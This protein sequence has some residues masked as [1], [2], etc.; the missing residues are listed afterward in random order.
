MNLTIQKLTLLTIIIWINPIYAGQPMASINGAACSF[1]TIADAISA[2]QPND[3]INIKAGTYNQLIGEIDMNL[4]LV[5]SDGVTGCEVGGNIFTTIDGSGQT[6]DATGGLVKVTNGAVVTFRDMALVNASAINGGIMAVLDE[7]S[8]F[9]DHVVIIN[10]SALTAGG[11]IYVDSTTGIESSLVLDN[12]SI[13][14]SGSVINGDGGGLAI[15]NSKLL[16]NNSTIGLMGMNEGNISSNNGAGIYAENSNLTINNFATQIQNNSANNDGGGIY[17][18]DSSLTITEAIVKDNTTGFNGGGIYL[19][20]TNVTLNNATISGNI[21]TEFLANSGGGGLYLTGS[22]QAMIDSTT[23]LSNISETLGGGILSVDANVSISIGSG[24]DIINNDARFGGGVFTISP[25]SV[26][27]SRILF[28]TATNS[29]GGISCNACQ[30]LSVV[31][32]SQVSNN[33]ASSSGGALDVFSN[34]TTTVEL[35]NSTFNGNNLTTSESSFGGAIAQDG[36][37]ILI[38]SSV[39]SNNTGAAN[40]GAVSLFDLENIVD[41]AR[42]L[43]SQFFDNSVPSSDFG[44]GGGALFL[45]GLFDAQVSGSHFNNNSSGIDGGAINLFESTLTIEDTI[46][47]EN[48]SI[49]EGGGIHAE[50][51]DLTIRN[52]SIIQNEAIDVALITPGNLGGGGIKSLDS[53]LEIVNSKINQNNSNDIGGGVFYNGSVDNSLSIYSDYG[54][55]TNECLPSSLGFN[56]YCSEISNNTAFLGSGLMIRGSTNEQGINL[57]G[58]ALNSNNVLSS[59]F[60]LVV[61]VAIELDIT[62]P[63]DTEV[64]MENLI[65][66]ENDGLSDLNKSVIH[67]SGPIILDLLS[68]TIANNTVRAIRTNP[69]NTAI[70]I[71]NSIFQQNN[72]GPLVLTTVPFIGICNNSEQSELGGSSIGANLGDPQFINTNRGNYRLSDTSPSLD[73]CSFGALLDIDGNVRPNSTS[74]FDQGAF[75]MHAD[76]LVDE[77]FMNSF[78]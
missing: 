6:F 73:V 20:N 5:A 60:G 7:S 45:S 65:L 47:S 42:I 29:G 57:T 22:S 70:S 19:D 8:V 59:P 51:S 40:G 14:H 12:G 74:T 62:N 36:G 68:S 58:V 31:N 50:D 52:S 34:S 33:T 78:E 26:D 24:S 25:V 3:V 37:T 28:N 77:I 15:Y 16:I 4:T 9:L 67:T 27:N 55:S 76:F 30:S 18:I 21:T 1:N 43:N 32:S 13:I 2:A 63:L 66:V 71:Q 46:I 48:S 61:G 56:E 10:G 64:T 39:I 44:L 23:L 17:A 11:N 35:R 49:F 54:I 53:N 75:E 69:D 72:H 41:S 38:E